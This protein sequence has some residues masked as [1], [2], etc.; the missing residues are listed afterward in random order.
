MENYPAVPPM[1]AVDE[2]QVEERRRDRQHLDAVRG[3]V[4]I[5]MSG[6]ITAVVAYAETPK[7]AEDW[8]FADAIIARI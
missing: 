5:G 7:R 3:D 2:H 1:R 8:G 6:K 4:Y